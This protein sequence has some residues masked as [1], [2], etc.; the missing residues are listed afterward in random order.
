[1]SYRWSKATILSIYSKRSY[2]VKCISSGHKYSNASKSKH[3]KV[4]SQLLVYQSSHSSPVLGFGAEAPGAD[5][6]FPIPIALVPIALFC[7][8]WSA[9]LEKSSQKS[10]RL[11]SSGAF[12]LVASGPSTNLLKPSCAFLPA[13]WACLASCAAVCWACLANSPSAI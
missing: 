5:D 1:M 13:S 12:L 3:L 4:Y 10:L 2:F 11:A 9:R 6:F 8:F 7:L